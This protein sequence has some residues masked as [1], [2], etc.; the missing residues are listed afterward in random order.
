[1]AKP[2]SEIMLRAAAV[3]LALLVASPAMAQSADAVDAKIDQLLGDHKD[4][5]RAFVVIQQA[6]SEHDTD[7]LAMY[8]PFGQSITVNGSAVTI[9]DQDDLNAQFSDIFNDKVVDAVANQTF[10]TLFVNS[11]GVMFG[12]GELWISGICQD[13]AC[14][15]A[16]VKITA[17][18]NQ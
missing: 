11:D 5:E 2:G 3:L 7:A 18:N 6:L 9:S 15:D 13:N 14:A 10:E 12:N 8:I 1:M 17:V 16:E 4:Y